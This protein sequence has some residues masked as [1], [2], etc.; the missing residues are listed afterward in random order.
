MNTL[1]FACDM[2]QLNLSKRF[3]KLSNIQ[4][5]SS[6]HRPISFF[7]KGG[8]LASGKQSARLQPWRTWAPGLGELP[9]PEPSRGGVGAERA[10]RGRDLRGSCDAR[11]GSASPE[12][13]E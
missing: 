5:A 13:P 11:P 10:G 6:L 12:T 4:D 7:Y 9:Y 8:G 2:I 1:Y 3:T